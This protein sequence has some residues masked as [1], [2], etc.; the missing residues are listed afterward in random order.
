MDLIS[1]GFVEVPELEDLFKL[2][3]NGSYSIAIP[4]DLRVL[5]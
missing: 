2:I 5:V 4:V 3:F 1:K